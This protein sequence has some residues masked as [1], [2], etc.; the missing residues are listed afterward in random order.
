MLEQKVLLAVP[1][2]R[3][4]LLSLY[5][6]M[7]FFSFWDSLFLTKQMIVARNEKELIPDAIPDAISDERWVR[8][9]SLLILDYDT[10]IL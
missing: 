10:S 8:A 1:E 2:T 9:Y 4:C 3:S 5:D 6:L 7:L